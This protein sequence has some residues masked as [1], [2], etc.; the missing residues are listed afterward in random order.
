[1]TRSFSS[2]GQRALDVLWGVLVALAVGLTA[3]MVGGLV[4]FY[5][6]YAVIGLVVSVLG[7]MGYLAAT[8]RAQNRG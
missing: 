6:A 3:V 7:L 2:Y 1:M 4:A 5:T 8:A